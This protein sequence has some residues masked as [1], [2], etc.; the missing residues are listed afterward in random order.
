[1]SVTKLARVL[2]AGCMS[3]SADPPVG[4][5]SIVYIVRI[6]QICQSSFCYG[7]GLPERDI[8]YWYAATLITWLPAYLHTKATTRLSD[9]TEAHLDRIARRSYDAL[10][11]CVQSCLA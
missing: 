7:V 2:E 3:R 9:T 5:Y 11:G 8:V 1:M 6:K 4:V 10:V